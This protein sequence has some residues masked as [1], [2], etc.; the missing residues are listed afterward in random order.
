M[1]I[2]DVMLKQFWART[3]KRLRPREGQFTN[4]TALI[5]DLP[6]EIRDEIYSLALGGRTIRFSRGTTTPKFT[7][8]EEHVELT[9][10]LLGTCRQVYSET[11]LIMYKTS[12]FV[13]ELMHLSRLLLALHPAQF[14]AIRKLEVT[15]MIGRNAHSQSSLYEYLTTFHHLEHITLHLKLQYDN[16]GDYIAAKEEFT[17]NGQL[18]QEQTRVILYL[19]GFKL[20][21]VKV[22]VEIDTDHNDQLFDALLVT[23]GDS[24][25]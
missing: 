22:T 24:K 16:A 13:G 8:A 14:L 18:L 11:E 10:G 20:K 9:P 6:R 5:F 19:Q 25:D 15:A 21:S 4:Q 23:A 12:T 7:I 1:W 17:D 3:T 2:K